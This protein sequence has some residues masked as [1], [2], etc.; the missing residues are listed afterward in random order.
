VSD[1]KRIELDVERLAQSYGLE[2]PVKAR[3]KGS[4]GR[5]LRLVLEEL[6]PKS[7]G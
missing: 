3:L 7:D 6:V 5:T 4:A 2:L 1:Q